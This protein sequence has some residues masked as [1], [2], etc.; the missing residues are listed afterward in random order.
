MTVSSQLSRVGYIMLVKGM[1][2]REGRE[3]CSSPGGGAQ[4]SAEVGPDSPPTIASPDCWARRRPGR[5]RGRSILLTDDTATGLLSQ[6]G[7]TM[8][9]HQIGSRYARHTP[10][11]SHLWEMYPPD[12]KV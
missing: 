10:P 1:L 7:E 12:C 8:Q 2:V 6:D 3:Q 9:V 4:T 5:R 11:I